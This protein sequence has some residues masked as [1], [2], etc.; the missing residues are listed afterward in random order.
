MEDKHEI[1]RTIQM[2]KSWRH[3]RLWAQTREMWDPLL[4]SS[5]VFIRA[6]LWRLLCLLDPSHLST[7]P[8]YISSLLPTPILSVSQSLDVSRPVGPATDLLQPSVFA[9]D[10][11]LHDRLLTIAGPTGSLPLAVGH[12]T[13]SRSVID[14]VYGS[15]LHDRPTI[16]MG[17]TTT[18][19]HSEDM[20]NGTK[21]VTVHSAMNTYIRVRQTHGNCNSK[22][23][24]GSVLLN[25]TRINQAE[26]DAIPNQSLRGFGVIDRVKSAVEKK[27]P[28]VV[29]CADIL[30]LTARDAVSLIKGPFW[31]VPLGRRDGR[32][33]IMMEALINLPPPFANI[34][35]LKAQFAANNLTTKDLVVLSGSHTIG[36]SHCSSFSSRLYNFTGRNDTDPSLDPNYIVRL[37]SKCKPAD[38]TTLVEMNPGSFKTFDQ[39]Y[40]TLVAKRRGLLQSDAA[41]LDDIETKAYVKLQSFSHGSTFFKDFATSMVKMGKI[42]VLTGNAGEIRK[43]CGFV[44]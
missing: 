8:S 31:K 20:E 27:C 6:P 44:N 32:L 28:G 23:C 42:G 35:Q 16:S 41:L 18:L 33:S 30:A 2:I 21:V 17:P 9:Y 5:I 13:E 12:Y 39:D 7:D 25:S 37:K 10:Y 1:F 22:G 36:T 15:S 29:S 4:I 43:R 3:S 40:Y 24:D 19:A 11:S 26:K 14:P 38:V 34:T